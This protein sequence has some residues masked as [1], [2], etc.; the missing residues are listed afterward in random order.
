MTKINWHSILESAN[1]GM[2]TTDRQQRIFRLVVE[3]HIASGEPISSDWVVERLPEQISGATVRAELTELENHHLLRQPHTSAGRVP[4]EKGYRY[5]IEA[6]VKPAN[7][8]RE[9]RSL[10]HAIKRTE[11]RE[12]QLRRA[13]RELSVLAGNIVMVGLDDETIYVT[14]LSHLFDEPEAQDVALLHSV[15]TALDRAEELFDELEDVST[16]DVQVLIG[17][18]NPIDAQ[19][20][21]LVTHRTNAHPLAMVGFMRMPYG[22]NIALLNAMKQIFE[23]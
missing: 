4:T 7:V 3:G 15:T 10:E 9:A 23:I 20:A 8:Q 2:T 18:H 21:M 13:A 11:T 16:D 22:R 6:F 14:G 1:F 12:E 17:R 19:C 5:Y